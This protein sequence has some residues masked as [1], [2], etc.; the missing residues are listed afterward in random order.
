MAS[1]SKL[2]CCCQNPS[3]DTYVLLD[4]LLASFRNRTTLRGYR[5][6]CPILGPILCLNP[7]R[8][9][10]FDFQTFPCADDTARPARDCGADAACGWCKCSGR[11]SGS[12]AEWLLGS[13]GHQCIAVSAGRWRSTVLAVSPCQWCA[14]ARTCCQFIAVSA[15]R[16]WRTRFAGFVPIGWCCADRG[17][18]CGWIVRASA[19]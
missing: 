19:A 9:I 7:C 11:V 6:L 4:G 5:I 13:P 3:V 16:W 8:R 18:R 14:S 12:V 10:A 2:P 15:C 1:Q 17:W